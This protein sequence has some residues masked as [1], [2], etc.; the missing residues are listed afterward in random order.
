MTGHPGLI[1]YDFLRA[2]DDLLLGEILFEPC[3]QGMP[4]LGCKLLGH[5]SD[6]VPLCF[7]AGAPQPLTGRADKAGHAAKLSGQLFQER[8]E[9]ALLMTA[10]PHLQHFQCL[11][12]HLRRQSP[13]I[14][15]RSHDSVV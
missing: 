6:V 2:N 13:D 7:T 1:K 3:A 4:K 10:S 15:T 12:S 8:F 5:D 9:P 14:Q 11:S